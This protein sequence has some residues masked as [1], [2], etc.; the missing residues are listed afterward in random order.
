VARAGAWNPSTSR[1]FLRERICLRERIGGAS[2]CDTGSCRWAAPHAHT[3]DVFAGHGSGGLMEG[4]GFL[5]LA[6]ALS[7]VG[8]FVLWL[9]SRGSQSIEAGVEGFNREMQALA[10]PSSRAGAVRSIERRTVDRKSIQE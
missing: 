6:L 10:P 9:R 7:V 4:V 8:G 1:R 5:L 3:V 2:R